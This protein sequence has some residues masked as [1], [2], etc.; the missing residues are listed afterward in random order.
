MDIN[1]IT[2]NRTEPYL[3]N[4]LESL[5]NSDWRL[6]NIPINLI[7]GSSEEDYV[8]EYPYN[9][10][11]WTGE[12]PKI[13]TESFTKNYIRALR[14]GEGDIFIFE[15]DI[16]FSRNW[17]MRTMFAIKEL[18][19]IKF[20]LALYT[21]QNVGHDSFARGRWY[22]SYPAKRF[23]GTQGMFYPKGIRN[24]VA[25]YLEANITRKPGDLLI[26][27]LMR[28]E[29]CLYVTQG[30]VLQHHGYVT[31]GLGKKCHKAWNYRK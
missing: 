31:T 10:V 23:Y 26:N 11:H 8:S 18:N 4:T 9:K 14:H 28:R 5:K 27:E 29:Q 7:M 30:S 6:K 16:E 15:D 21:A 25:D 3:K 2:I 13:I 1:I 22:R 20:I 17:L 19:N 12:R 24:L